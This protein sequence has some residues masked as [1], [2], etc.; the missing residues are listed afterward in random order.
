MICLLFLWLTLFHIT[1][2]L[3]SRHAIYR[4]LVFARGISVVVW[5][6]F[7]CILIL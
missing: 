4:W 2:K 7:V 1:A 5:L 3:Q 6:V